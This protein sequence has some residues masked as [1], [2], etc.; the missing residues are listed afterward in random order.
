MTTSV[1]LI[2]ADQARDYLDRTAP[3]QYSLLDVRQ[4]WEYEEFHIPGARLIPLADLL[5]RLED[6]PRDKPVLVYCLSGGRSGAAATLLSGQGYEDVT[7]MVGGVMAW[8]GHTA[9][10]PMELGM[11]E[12][13]GRETPQ[14][15]VLKAYAMENSLQTFYVERADFAETLERIELFME[16]AGF[17]DRHKDTLFVYYQKI[18][19]ETISRKLFEE[20]AL[21]GAGATVEGGLG[22]NEFLVAFGEAFDEDQ[23]VLQFASMVEAQALDYYLRCAVVAEQPEARQAFETLARE[24]KAHL[25]LLAR[26]MDRREDQS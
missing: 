26:N 18:L 19:G 22:I 6:I 13:T 21:A 15:V 20:V 2:S 5:D 17:E 11:I 4:D 12:F 8:Q 10:G 7:S 3:T 24:E 14:E 1:K 9:F 25:K 16:L 23:G